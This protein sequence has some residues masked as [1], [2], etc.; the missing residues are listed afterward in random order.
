[1]GDFSVW[2]HEYKLLIPLILW[3]NL[4]HVGST[5]SC[6]RKQGRK[7]LKGNQLRKIYWMSIEYG[8]VQTKI[9]SLEEHTLFIKNWTYEPFKIL[10][11]DLRLWMVTKEWKGTLN[12]LSFQKK[13]PFTRNSFSS[14]FLFIPFFVEKYRT[15]AFFVKFDKEQTFLFIPTILFL[16][17]S[18]L[19]VI[20]VP[21]KIT[22]RSL[23]V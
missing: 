11:H 1:M 3:S 12:S 13:S 14:L 22:S 5:V 7:E 6:Q 20:R 16:Y 9:K 2:I 15:K 10:L 21:E 8:K 4:E 23:R 18:F 19:F 17:V